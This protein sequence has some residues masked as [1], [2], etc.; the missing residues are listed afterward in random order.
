MLCEPGIWKK[1]PP[2]AP[3]PHCSSARLGFT[4]VLNG[5]T[6]R[7]ASL[8]VFWFR[9]PGGQGNPWHRDVWV[10]LIF[11]EQQKDQ[12]LLYFLWPSMPQTRKGAVYWCHIWL[13]ME[14]AVLVQDC[15]YILDW[16]GK[17][18]EPRPD[19][20]CMPYRTYGRGFSA[21]AATK[22]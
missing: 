6:M 11:C 4:W 10:C 18:G 14:A 21:S 5:L 9:R 1:D 19:Y 12:V 8:R 22:C 17:A 3:R 7:C 20:C 13:S 15:G 16:S 2:V